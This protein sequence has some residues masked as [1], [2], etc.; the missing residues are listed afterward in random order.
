VEK[1]PH[2]GLTSAGAL[3]LSSLLF[4]GQDA[5]SRIGQLLQSFAAFAGTPYLSC[6]MPAYLS[7]RSTS[8]KYAP[9]SSFC[10][11]VRVWWC[12]C[13]CACVH[14]C[15]FRVCGVCGLTDNGMCGIYVQRLCA[16]LLAEELRRAR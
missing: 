13:V 11:C 15:L 8:N 16:G 1:K 10:A 3:K 2:N 7:L 9:H 6:S 4:A 14:E 5:P 12:V